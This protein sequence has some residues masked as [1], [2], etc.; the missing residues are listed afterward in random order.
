MRIR[1][2]PATHVPFQIDALDGF[3]ERTG[4]VQRRGKHPRRTP[5]RV[6]QPKRLAHGV[7]DR[8]SPWHSHPRALR[9]PRT[10]IRTAPS[11]SLADRQPLHGSHV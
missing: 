5:P 9:C 1:L 6:H 8:A 11:R 3:H 2:V 10:P 4:R 7:V